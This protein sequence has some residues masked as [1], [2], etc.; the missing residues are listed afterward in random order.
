[1]VSCFDDGCL[2][3]FGCDVGLFV[4][5]SHLRRERERERRDFGPPLRDFLGGLKSNQNFCFNLE[6][7]GG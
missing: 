5:D 2:V 4:V 6:P 3:N 7:M 1:L